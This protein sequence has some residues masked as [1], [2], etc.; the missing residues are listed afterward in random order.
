MS[1]R[2]LPVVPTLKALVE[3]LGP[4]SDASLGPSR[5]DLKMAAAARLQHQ[6]ELEEREAAAREPTPRAGPGGLAAPPAAVAAAAAAASAT[7]T[8]SKLQQLAALQAEVARL[9]A[10]KGRRGG[11]AMRITSD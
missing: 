5:S 9:Q 4:S 2:Q 8:A 11:A 10:A 1:E 6:V 7:A 3:V